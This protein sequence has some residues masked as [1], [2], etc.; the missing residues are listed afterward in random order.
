MNWSLGDPFIPEKIT[1]KKAYIQL[2]TKSEILSI[3]IEG[4]NNEI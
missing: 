1:K 3:K 2:F 4:K